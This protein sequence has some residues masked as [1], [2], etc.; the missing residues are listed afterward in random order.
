MAEPLTCHR[1]QMPSGMRSLHLVSMPFGSWECGSVVLWAL[2]FRT[3]T[4]AYWRTFDGLCPTSVHQTTWDHRIAC[5]VTSSTRT[6]EGRRGLPLHASNFR[7]AA[8][9]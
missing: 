1:Y 8:C 9:T 7:S 4:K 6:L 3:L 2:Q 5:E